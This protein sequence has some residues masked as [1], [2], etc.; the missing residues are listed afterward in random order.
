MVKG[1]TNGTITDFDGNYTIS[2]LPQNA[3][4]AFSFVGMK[5]QEI[6]VG[7]QTAINVQLMADAIGIDA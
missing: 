6:V 5:P 3:I 1:T 2:N 4:L 7:S